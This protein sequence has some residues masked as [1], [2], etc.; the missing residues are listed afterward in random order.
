MSTERRGDIQGLRA[1]AVLGVVIYHIDPGLLPGGFI[2]VDIFFVISGYL[3]LG[4]LW[5]NIADG[6]FSLLDFYVRRAKRLLPALTVVLLATSVAAYYLMLHEEYSNYTLSLA[7]SLFYVSNFWFYTQAGYFSSALQGDPLLHTWSLSVEEQFY[8]FFPLLMLALYK[9]K[10]NIMLGLLAV[11]IASFSLSEILLN[12][13]ADFS[14]YASPSRFWQFIVGGLV[15]IQFKNITLPKA[16][17]ELLSFCCLLIISI[18]MF[19]M[20]P[21]DFPGVKALIPTLATALLLFCSTRGDLAYAT[22]SNPI[23]MF[24]GNSSYSL[25]LWHWPVIVFYKISVSALPGI[26]D[27]III[28]LTSM[29]LGYLSYIAIERTTQHVKIKSALLNPVSISIIILTLTC[30]AVFTL[31]HE[32][33]KRF[34]EEGLSFESFLSYQAAESESRSGQCLLTSSYNDFSYFNQ[35]EC[36]SIVKNKKKLL[37]I[38]DSHAAHWYQALNEKLSNT[39]AITQVTAS[40]CK[41]TIPTQGEKRCTD[42]INW[43]YTDLLNQYQFDQIVISAR[44]AIGDAEN[45]KNTITYL[46]K[47]ASSILVLGPIIEYD[48][49]L[50]RLLA[51]YSDHT[52]LSRHNRYEK[53]L[54]IDKA[55]AT[56]T[57][58]TG[59]KYISILNVTCPTKET[60]ITEANA[61]PLQFDF[62]HLT[63][64]GAKKL[65]SNVDL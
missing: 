24:F 50:P 30:I 36:I 2:G 11:L 44:W 56:A 38:G 46:K 23:A 54:D 40:G 37:L 3:I 14:F 28:L 31:E 53:I 34:T 4:H 13:N 45:L 12:T 51:T 17:R 58:M 61:T 55:I 21:T 27:K 52:T 18:S 60:C 48:T 49:D 6:T 10:I 19:L 63:A 43:G 65:L 26:P 25:Y 47:Y 16:A 9:N 39:T 35:D 20:A 15:S 41:P 57:V 1:I 59:A 22:L 29:L 33:R 62:C 5:R 64:A 32:H 8:I 42:L 7:S